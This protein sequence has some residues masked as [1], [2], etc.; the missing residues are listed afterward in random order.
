VKQ[1]SLPGPADQRS[2]TLL[3]AAPSTGWRPEGL[4]LACECWILHKMT[5]GW[6]QGPS[7]KD[8]AKS[9]LIPVTS[10][11]REKFPRLLSQIL[12]LPSLQD[13]FGLFKSLYV[14]K[15]TVSH[16]IIYYFS[17]LNN[18]TRLMPHSPTMY[19][20]PGI[21]KLMENVYSLHNTYSF[22]AHE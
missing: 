10:P 21:E 19:K 12:L 1:M 9:E 17:L 7:L 5:W 15:M 11:C 18:E 14:P 13:P 4:W 20:E 6:G 2:K 3:L 16:I 22:I 8:K